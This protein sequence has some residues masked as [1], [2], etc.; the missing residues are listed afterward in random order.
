MKPMHRVHRSKSTNYCLKI[1]L[2]YIMLRTEHRKTL[3]IYAKGDYHWK[4]PKML[5][6][7]MY[8][9]VYIYISYFIFIRYNLVKHINLCSEASEASVVV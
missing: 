4:V 1:T 8:K 7:N 2:K 6:C 5:K 3:V 9:A